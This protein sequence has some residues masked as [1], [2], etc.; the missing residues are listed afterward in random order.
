MCVCVCTR[1][2]LP[3]MPALFLRLVNGAVSTCK[4]RVQA[5]FYQTIHTNRKSNATFSELLAEFVPA[6]AKR[7][8]VVF[9]VYRDEKLQT[10]IQHIDERFVNF[11]RD[12][13]L[14]DIEKLYHDLIFE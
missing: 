4:T 7:K 10:R 5:L 9:W 1:A 11:V 2:K 8:Q 3:F 6:K 14:G 13:R 12:F